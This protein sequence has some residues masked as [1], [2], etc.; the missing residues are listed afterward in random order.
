MEV[1]IFKKNEIKSSLFENI[2]LFE[3]HEYLDISELKNEKYGNFMDL[4]SAKCLIDTL[5]KN[6]ETNR[7]AAAKY[8]H[9]YELVK[10]ICKKQVI[11]R[12]Y[13]KLYEIIYNEPL[14]LQNSLQ[15]FF[16]CEAPGGFIECVSDIRRKKNL[17]VQYISVSKY[18]Q[19]I[20]YDRYLEESNLMYSDIT[21][22][23]EIN[24]VIGNVLN[25]FPNKLDF[26]TAD[27]GFDV[28]N[29]N[30]QE[31]IS[32][33]LL[34]CEIYIALCTQRIGGMFVIKFFD[35][36]THNTIIYY[37]ILCTFYSYVKIIKPKTSRNCNSERYLV[38]YNFKG[39]SGNL[40]LGIWETILNFKISETVCTVIYPDFDFKIPGL[41]KIT[42]FNNLLVYEQIKT[43]HESIKM[44][45]GK[46]CYFQNML[47]NIFLEK[48]N[49]YKKTV[50]IYDNLFYFKHILQSRIKK[51]TD[52]LRSYNININ[53]I[54]YKIN[55][56]QS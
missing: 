40:L 18:D 28:K 5:D 50:Q 42:S 36:F 8:L 44:V 13:F 41:S 49:K 34:L 4:D 43:I 25:K 16:I 20:K 7:R 2:K 37:L 9:E 26:I 1:V 55:K 12:A 3:Q 29:F 54:I 32:S 10:L 47:L 38:C 56:D 22:P 27:G 35:M 31:I 11:S 51:C 19:F 30:A 33:K 17:R 39:T 24:K 52:F 14:I 48:N 53:Q 23:T 45:H 21:S 46:D 15:C 6:A